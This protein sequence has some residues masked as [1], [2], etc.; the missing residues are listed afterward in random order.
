LPALSPLSS[1]SSYKFASTS[2]APRATTSS[3]HPA[4]SC[5]RHQRVREAEAAGGSCRVCARA[6]SLWWRC[7]CAAAAPAASTPK[8]AEAGTAAAV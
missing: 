3:C 4:P 7:F 2:D 6:F 5:H 1:L 8:A